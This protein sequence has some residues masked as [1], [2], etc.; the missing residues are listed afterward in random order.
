MLYLEYDLGKRI[1]Y[2][3]QRANLTQKELGEKV[4]L[5]ESTIRN[6]ELGNRKPDFDT[7]VAIA[8][9]LKVSYYTLKMPPINVT[10]QVMHMFFEMEETYNLKPIFLEDNQVGFVFD[11]KR[12]R[13]LIGD[14]PTVEELPRPL[15]K[16]EEDELWTLA[17][18]PYLPLY[19][20]NMVESWATV[21][22]EFDRGTIDLE[23]YLSWKEKYPA[24]AGFD[25]N[26]APTLYDENQS[27]VPIGIDEENDNKVL[28][29]QTETVPAIPKGILVREED[30]EE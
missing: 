25:E 9:A 18:N 15:T 16:E 20:E 24:F 13:E 3:R 11:T 26:G 17:K 1:R 28:Y 30:I 6:Y 4:D 12:I 29:V 5:N 21:V 19:L 27:L 22:E 8:D 2:Y 23:T 10:T 7:L 14:D